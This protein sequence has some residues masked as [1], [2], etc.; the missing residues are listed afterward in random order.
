MLVGELPGS[1][2][3]VDVEDHTFWLERDASVR[4]ETEVGID[5]EV[6]N[7]L[8]VEVDVVDFGVGTVKTYR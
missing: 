6:V 3:D 7:P 8:D 2:D 1:I 5:R 4:R